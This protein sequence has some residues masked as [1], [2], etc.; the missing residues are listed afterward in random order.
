MQVVANLT[1]EALAASGTEPLPNYSSALSHACELHPPPFGMAWYGEK[2]RQVSTDPSWLANSLIANAAKEGEGSRKLWIL[3][4]RTEDGVVS[5]QVRLHAVDEARHAKLYIEMLEIAFPQC[6]ESD[7]RSEL[8]NLSPGYTAKQHP[9]RLKPAT[10]A[11]VLDELIQMNI[12][13]IRTRIHQLLLRPV[14]T[15][16]CPPENRRQLARVLDSLLKDET[17]HIE[18]TARLIERAANEGH[19]EFVQS[20]FEKRLAEFNQI[21]LHEV[22]ESQF[23]GA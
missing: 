14:I 21:T 3:A 17:S 20:T 4:G 13:E 11:H 19:I 23:E 22:G 9:D 12:G 18:Y 16:H 5:D 8:D 1:I 15:A 10:K 6:V 7:M 2:Y